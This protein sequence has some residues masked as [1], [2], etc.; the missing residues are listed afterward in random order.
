M[1]DIRHGFV[2]G[3]KKQS[4]VFKSRPADVFCGGYAISFTE[5]LC[6]GT[7]GYSE[8]LGIDYSTLTVPDKSKYSRPEVK[9]DKQMYV[10]QGD[11]YVEVVGI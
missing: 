5:D 8:V 6:C 11:Y 10:K 7:L 2:G 1:G 3:F 4:C 9:G